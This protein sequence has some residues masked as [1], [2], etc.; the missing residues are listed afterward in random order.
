ML[1]AHRIA[2]LFLVEGPKLVPLN[3]VD[4]PNQESWTIRLDDCSP[5]YCGEPAGIRQCP[6]KQEFD[7]G[8][9][10]PQLVA[11]PPGQGIVYRGVE[12]E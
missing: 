3:V 7:L 8:V 2:H 1:T 6:A 4:S 5:L 11:G 12:P 10:A 9:G